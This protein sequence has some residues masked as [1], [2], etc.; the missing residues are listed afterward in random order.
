MVLGSLLGRYEEAVTSFIE[1][2][3]ITQ[4]LT[5]ICK[6]RI[7]IGLRLPAHEAIANTEIAIRLNPRDPSVF[8]RYP[9][10]SL[11]YFIERDFVT[12][13]DWAQKTIFSKS[14]W[15]LGHALLAASRAHLQ[16]TEGAREAGAE[17][18]RL[19]PKF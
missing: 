13:R 16:D 9:A 5:R 3:R 12:A 18:T 2:L 8:F 15:W 1:A 17:L 11:A 7:D 10:L 14:E 4:L 19:F 6:S